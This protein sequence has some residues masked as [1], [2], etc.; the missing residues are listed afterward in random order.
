MTKIVL[1]R[2]I[3][4]TEKNLIRIIENYLGIKNSLVL[5]NALFCK[6]KNL[7]SLVIKFIVASSH[8]S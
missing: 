7:Y 4:R 8:E 5:N 3:L 1:Y 6:I 2:V